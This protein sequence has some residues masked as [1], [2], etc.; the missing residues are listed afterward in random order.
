VAILKAFDR[1]LLPVCT[2]LL[3]ALPALGLAQPTVTLTTTHAAAAEPGQDADARFR[4]S[5]GRK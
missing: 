3:L 1:R 2:W 5:R 4:R